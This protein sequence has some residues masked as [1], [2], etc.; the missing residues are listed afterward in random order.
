MCVQLTYFY[1]A[2]ASNCS[3]SFFSESPK[4]QLPD[5]RYFESMDDGRLGD[6]LGDSTSS[7]VLLSLF[8]LFSRVKNEF[9]LL[10][11]AFRSVLNI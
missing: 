11:E 10:Q 2:L 6:V 1:K 8:C 4:H 5:L 9:Y 7:P 3:F